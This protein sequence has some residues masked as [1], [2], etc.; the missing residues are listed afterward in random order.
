MDAGGE[1]VKEEPTEE[2]K[3]RL[4]YSMSMPSIKPIS[5]YGRNSLTF[6]FTFIKKRPHV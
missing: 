3:Y 5:I 1:K 6:S 4:S 2:K